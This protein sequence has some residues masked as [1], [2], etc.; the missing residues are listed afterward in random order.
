MFSKSTAMKDNGGIPQGSVLGP[1]LSVVYTN[2]FPDHILSDI[3]HF[4]DGT[5]IFNHIR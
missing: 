3:F 5:K 4:S 1:F 2:D